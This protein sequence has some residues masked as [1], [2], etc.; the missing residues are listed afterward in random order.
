M[1]LLH[2]AQSHTEIVGASHDAVRV[3]VELV[4]RL[5]SERLGRVGEERRRRVQQQSAD[6]TRLGLVRDADC[7]VGGQCYRWVY[8]FVGE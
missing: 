6:A 2:V 7:L 4:S 5:R 8:V 3:L 1:G